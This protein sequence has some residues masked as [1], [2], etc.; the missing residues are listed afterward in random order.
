MIDQSCFLLGISSIL[1]HT[2]ILLTRDF[3]WDFMMIHL[4]SMNFF[5]PVHVVGFTFTTFGLLISDPMKA[6]NKKIH[7]ACQ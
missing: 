2:N 6:G 5:I 1:S 4:N 7:T 3:L